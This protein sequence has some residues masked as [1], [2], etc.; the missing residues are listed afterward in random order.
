[1]DRRAW[2]GVGVAAIVGAI[3]PLALSGDLGLLDGRRLVGTG[4]PDL[5]GHTFQYAA[6]ARQVL[7]E[8]FA[9]GT[10]FPEGQGLWQADP[11]VPF[12][13][14]PI[15]AAFGAPASYEA[16]LVAHV[17]LMA[18]GVAWALR[19]RGEALAVA[20][21]LGIVAATHPYVRGVAASSLPE[22]LALG[23]FAPWATLFWAGL[24]G[25]GRAR[26]AAAVVGVVM[27]LDGLYTALPFAAASL[28][29]GAAAVASRRPIREVVVGGLV[30]GLPVAAAAVGAWSL[31]RGVGNGG[32]AS[33]IALPPPVVAD[34]SWTVVARG[35]DLA[36]PFVPAF[37]LPRAPPG[38]LH[39]HTVYVGWALIAAAIVG[40]RR[41]RVARGLVAVAA[42]ALLFALGPRL[43]VWGRVVL[44]VPM[45]GALASWLGAHH[46]YRFMGVATVALL[47]AAAA[48]LR[49]RPQAVQVAWAAIMVAEGLAFAPVEAFPTIPNPVGAV[50]ARLAAAEGAVL[51]LPFDRECDKIRGPFPQRAFYVQAVHG[52]PIASAFCRLPFVVGTNATV[53][54]LDQWVLAAWREAGLVSPV[55]PVPD[56]PVP[57]FDIAPPDLPASAAADRAMLA[58]AGFR[59][60]WVDL[61]ALPPGAAEGFAAKLDSWLG[62]PA[63]ATASRRLWPLSPAASAAPASR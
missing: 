53:K 9:V 51:D 29:L 21:L 5:W 63:E 30:A 49:G 23:F 34:G 6:V 3:S 54:A 42:V 32:I 44:P 36:S 47:G 56:G 7:G 22:V 62:A 57:P 52:R 27:V 12:L 48:G 50:E 46:A 25:S 8:P 13:L 40:A 16:L 60:V 35:V 41:D 17:A 10:G 19:W 26:V 37:L 18:A 15:T 24:M 61:D 28:A 58:E 14:V 31:Y 55:A 43:G 59:W 20:V 33:A 11:V 2:G 39:R 45:P 4:T 38:F 1:M